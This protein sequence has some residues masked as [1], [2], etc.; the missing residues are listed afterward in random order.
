MKP[1]GVSQWKEYGKRFGY[2]DFFV[3]DLL[4]RLPEE[5]APKCVHG[6]IYT[7]CCG[8][9]NP[10]VKVWNKCLAEVRKRLEKDK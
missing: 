1:M 9:L 7:V 6:R 4:A 5:K 8:K 2:W 10:D 3:K